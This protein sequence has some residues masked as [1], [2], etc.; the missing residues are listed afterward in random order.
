MPL[1]DS[2][3]SEAPPV[4]QCWRGP[5][6][7]PKQELTRHKLT[8]YRLGS[9]RKSPA[10]EPGFLHGRSHEPRGNSTRISPH[11]ER[12]ERH[13]FALA[14]RASCR[15]ASTAATSPAGAYRG[16]GL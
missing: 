2:G 5:L 8:F 14:W 1:L 4:V 7:E 16:K 3:Q 15:S 11:W 9:E 12:R 6:A 13:A 10:S